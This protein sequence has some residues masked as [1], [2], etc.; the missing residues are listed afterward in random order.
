MQR[1]YFYSATGQLLAEYDNPSA[2][3]APSRTTS[4]FSGQRVGQWT[5]RVGSKRADSGSAAQYYP[6]GEEITGTSNDTFK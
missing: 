6:Y 5:D 3:S 4:Y 2:G 1:L